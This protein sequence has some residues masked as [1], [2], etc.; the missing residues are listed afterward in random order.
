MFEVTGHNLDLIPPDAVC[1]VSQHNETPLENRGVTSYWAFA[2]IIEQSEGR[3]VF[4]NERTAEYDGPHYLGA[5]LSAD[6]QTIYWV[7]ET[8]PLP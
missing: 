5:I 4:D 6:R 2:P 3:L 8:Q 1:V 7:N